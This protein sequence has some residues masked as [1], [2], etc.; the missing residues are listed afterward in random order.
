MHLPF[1][2]RYSGKPKL[3]GGGK[4]NSK[5]NQN[6]VNRVAHGAYIKQRAGEL[7][8]F[9]HERRDD[10]KRM[11]LPDINYGIP[12]LLEIDPASDVE[13]LRG[14]G[15]EI[16][17][18]IED[19][20]IVVATDDVD[21]IKLSEK[22]DGFINEIS[23]NC[24]SPAKIY[25]MC[26]DGDRLQRILSNKL[27]AD[28]AELEDSQ[29]YY[30]DIGVSCGGTIPLPEKPKRNENETD[31]H[32]NQ[33]C[34][35]WQAK[36]NEAYQKWDDLASER[37]ER[38]IE[39]ITAYEGEIPSGFIGETD[40]FS[41][42]LIISGKGLRD[43]ILNY[44]YIFEVSEMP[45]VKMESSSGESSITSDNVE[46]FPPEDDAPIVCVIDSGIQEAHK[47]IAQAIVAEDSICLIPKE[48]SVTD[49]VPVGGHGTRVAGAV[50][51]PNEVVRSGTY[52]LPHF[53]RNAK[54]L[55]SSN[56]LPA[57]IIPSQAIAIVTKLFSTNA[58][59][60][61]KVY[62]HSICER[63]PFTSLRHMSLW[64]AQIDLQSYENDVL[65]IQAAGN[66][67]TTIISALLQ[68][69]YPYPDYLG[70]NDL[71]RLA[72][73]AQSL[74][75]ITVGSVSLSNYETEDMVSMGTKDEI[76]SYSRIGPGI[77]DT[78]KPDVVEYGGT[79]AVNKAGSD[80]RFTTPPDVC[81][82]LIRRSPPGAAY[83]RDGIGTS[84]AAPK[85]ANI[86]AEIER[87][88][89]NSP[90]LLYRA[91]VAHSARWAE[92][93]RARTPQECED[94]LRRIGYGL[95]NVERAT[96]NDEYRV[97]LITPSVTE[98][99]VDEAHVYNIRIPDEL[100][101]V[102]EDFDILIEVTLSYTA[103]PRRTR[104]Y[105]RGYLSTWVDWIASKNNESSETFM[106]R[107][108]NEGRA[109][110]DSGNFK[111]FLGERRGD[112]H[113]QISNYSRSRGTLQKDWCIIK[114]NQLTD[115]FC[116]AVRAHKGWGSLFKA[117][118]SLSVSFE[119]IN[120][121]VLIY[122]PIR[123]QNTIEIETQE[124]NI[125]IQQPKV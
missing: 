56:S 24:N 51:Y 86:V 34:N 60:P 36:F 96:H 83:D 120:Q 32:Y 77:W 121:D 112:G 25:A 71:V 49:D 122:E 110:D 114:S 81:P 118:Y 52:R 89:P 23:R 73:P 5:T 117:K 66:I 64:A 76:A 47:Y 102:G 88:F 104:R 119:A 124:I 40:S 48:D 109:I 79:Y 10:R 101:A 91:L 113:G 93:T 97:T 95:P 63:G 85:V 62:N 98:I 74:Q 41:F 55:D 94:M 20:F 28:W 75:A 6:K 9:W 82:E 58:K 4:V 68:S 78:I 123:I 61:S 3:S 116:I 59:S 13:F 39:I 69:G 45:E 30:V 22:A 72:N 27:Y 33:R 100:S 46:I 15:F 1:P 103:K 37:Q 108:F 16:I 70:N 84:F 57:D 38:I 115:E 18:S 35:R 21:L 80:V 43:F 106:R 54:I 2:H 8:R 14:L 42:R 17:C 50:L 19:G 12:F 7:S 107:V 65:F 11:G 99:G 67:P 90:A 87:I 111:W 92:P 53:I 26:A 125:E 44:P 105:I 29:T 31:E